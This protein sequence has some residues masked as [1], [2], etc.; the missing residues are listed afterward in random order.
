MGDLS[1]KPHEQKASV[2]GQSLRLPSVERGVLRAQT[3]P[4]DRA[5]L[6]DEMFPVLLAAT[7]RDGH[8]THAEAEERYALHQLVS[9]EK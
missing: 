4:L 5:N 6:G 7:V 8:I 3:G 9:G 2:S 1:A